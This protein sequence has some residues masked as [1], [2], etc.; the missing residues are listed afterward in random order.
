MMFS[1]HGQVA[2]D[3]LAF[4][5]SGSRPMPLCMASMG[6]LILASLPSTFR[7]PVWALS[8]P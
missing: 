2:D 6:W 3:A 4:R 8:A 7:V 5:S 1:P